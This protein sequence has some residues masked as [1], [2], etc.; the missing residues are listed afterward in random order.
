MPPKELNAWDD[1]KIYFQA[2]APW[3]EP[4]LIRKIDPIVESFEDVG[5]VISLRKLAQRFA[6]G[7]EEADRK[8]AAYAAQ[9]KAWLAGE[10]D[11]LLEDL[12]KET[13]RLIGTKPMRTE[14]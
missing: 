4:E 8:A 9:V 10:A 13:R 14:G 7:K 5:D 12:K 1:L 3:L 6:N 2:N 11:Q